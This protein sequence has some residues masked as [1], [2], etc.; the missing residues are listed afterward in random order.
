MIS[1]HVLG[2]LE[3]AAGARDLAPTAP[4]VKAVLALLALNA[5][6][7]VSTDTLFAELW[8]DRPPRSAATTLQ[9]Y[10]YQLR[11]ILDSVPRGERRCE[12]VTKAPG[13]ELRTGRTDA[14]RFLAL[15]EQGRCLWRQGHVTEAAERLRQ[16]LGLWR[17]EALADINLG[18]ELT[19]HKAHLCELRLRVL[20]LRIQADAR[21]GRHQELIP[22]LRSLVAEHRLNERLHAQLIDSLRAA[23]YRAEA[24]QAYQD[25]RKVLRTELGLEPTP[26]VQRLQAEVL[27]GAH[28]GSVTALLR[29]G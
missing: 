2:Q 17:G 19:M 25:L 5:N 14:E 8:D 3:V 20:E 27:N 10:V 15:A 24:L 21:L 11:R 22:E 9:T 16:A 7:V 18:P 28:G 1:F 13:Y 29:T 26:E 12:I 6:R 23:G 4:R